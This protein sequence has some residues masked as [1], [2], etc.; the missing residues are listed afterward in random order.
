MLRRPRKLA[1]ANVVQGP[2]EMR[3]TSSQP[4]FGKLWVISGLDIVMTLCI[5]MTLELKIVTLIRVNHI[6]KFYSL[7]KVFFKFNWVQKKGIDKQTLDEKE[8][9]GTN[10]TFLVRSNWIG[11]ERKSL[12]V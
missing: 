12:R 8:A 1:R 3:L 5:N 7:E 4:C 11:F 2:Q 10:E 9:Y 6:R